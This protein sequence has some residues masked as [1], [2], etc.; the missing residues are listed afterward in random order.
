[1]DPFR[2]TYLHLM[3]LVVGLF[4]YMHGLVLYA[5][6]SGHVAIWRAFVAG[7]FLVFALLGNVLGKVRR[8]FY[9]GW[10]VPWTLASDRVWNDTHRLAAWLSVASGLVGFAIVIAGLPIVAAVAVLMVA[11]VVPVIYS[12]VHYKQARTPGRAVIGPRDHSPA[13]IHRAIASGPGRPASSRRACA[14]SAI[15]VGI[16]GPI[17]VET[18][19][20]AVDPERG[21]GGQRGGG[22]RAAELEQAGQVDLGGDRGRAVAGVELVQVDRGPRQA[23]QRRTS[24]QRLRARRPLRDEAHL[25]HVGRDRAQARTVARSC[26]RSAAS[27]GL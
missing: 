18:I 1:M 6:A 11:V 14:A 5:S 23:L 17:L 9:I 2:S 15:A 8:N 24:Q 3:V 27:D 13:S 21:G 25:A 22:L 12:F 7:A 16:R 20:R 19:A 26:I 4:G 10:R